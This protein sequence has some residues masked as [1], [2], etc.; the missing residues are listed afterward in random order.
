MCKN[1]FMVNKT[2]KFTYLKVTKRVDPKCFHHKK[3]NGRYV[4]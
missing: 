3:R 2:M 4:R 1:G